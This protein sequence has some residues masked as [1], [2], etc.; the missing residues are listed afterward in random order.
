M[1][2]T[3][4]VDDISTGL[5][6]RQRAGVNDVFGLGMQR[7]QIDQNAALAQEVVQLRHAAKA[8]HTIHV[9]QRAAPAIDLEIKHRQRLGH[10]LAHLAQAHH[11]HG[12]VCTLGIA[13]VL[14]HTLSHVGFVLVQPTEE[15]NHRLRHIFG[16]L[17]CHA[18]V[19]QAV[20]GQLRRNRQ[21]QQ[22]IYPRADVEH[23]FQARSLL[24]DELLGRRPDQGVISLRHTRLPDSDLGT[25]QS[26]IQTFEPGFWPRIFTAKSDFHRCEA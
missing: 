11:T 9:A 15:A 5:Q 8:L 23:G 7:Q 1:T 17:H 3:P 12:I 24:V 10:A 25:G 6:Q 14:P 21:R 20:D 22:C 16:H 13:L 18:R 4:H 26:L 2:A 19:F